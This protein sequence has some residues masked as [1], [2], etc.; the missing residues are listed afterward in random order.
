MKKM[1]FEF[2]RKCHILW[3]NHIMN[4]LSRSGQVLSFQCNI[5]GHFVQAPTTDVYDREKASC[6]SCHSNLRLRSI[7]HLLSCFLFGKSIPL[8]EFPTK[9]SIVGLGISDWESYANILEKK[10][11][12]QNTF[13]HKEPQFDLLSPPPHMIGAF[14]FVIC[15]DVLEH[16]IPP[17]QLAFANLINIL[18]PGGFCILTVPYMHYFCTLEHFPD[19]YKYELS[20]SAK[21]MGVVLRNT[22]RTG[23]RQVYDDLSFHGGKGT[24]LEM[25]V[26]SRMELL[27]GLKL[28]GFSDICFQRYPAMKYGISW[29]YNWSLPLTARKPLLPNIC[30]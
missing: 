23:V 12:Y 3:Y 24:T 11:S 26:F 14:D 22:T 4:N 13:Y 27:K 20:D 9:N 30:V 1:A 19:L 28:A 21:G 16:V 18:K 17:V 25:R 5:C 7:V 8:P 29:P 15:S 6:D 2:V 10:F